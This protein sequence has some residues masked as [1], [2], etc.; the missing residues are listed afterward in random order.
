MEKMTT[1]LFCT[2]IHTLKQALVEKNQLKCIDNNYN[3]TKQSKNPN[4]LTCR[5]F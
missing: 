2:L 5:E 1:K 3:N 4:S